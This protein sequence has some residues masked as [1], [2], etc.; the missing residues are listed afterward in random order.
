MDINT[1]F[2]VLAVIWV[3]SPIPL[4]VLL[5]SEK[6]KTKDLR[7]NERYLKSEL[8]ILR[9]KLSD[10]H[11]SGRMFRDESWDK[12]YEHEA[13]PAETARAE[14][15][16]VPSSVPA[17][18]KRREQA[19]QEQAKPVQTSQVAG[20]VRPVQPARPVYSAPQRKA[21]PPVYTYGAVSGQQSRPVSD[22]RPAEYRNSHSEPQTEKK[23]ASPINIILALGTLF[24]SLA[25]FVFAGSAWGMLS[26]LGRGAVLISFSVLFF[27]IHIIAE[28][29]L[30][31]PSAGKV[32]YILGSV[33]LPA[34]VFSAAVLKVFGDG[35]SFSDNNGGLVIS[36][37]ALCA[38]ICSLTG[39][40]HYDSRRAARAGYIFITLSGAAIGVFLDGAF[41]AAEMAVVA[42]VI[43]MFEGPIKRSEHINK[44]LKDEYSFFVS[45][46]IYVSAL[47]SLFLS[48]GSHIFAVPVLIF[49]AAFLISALRRSQKS[50]D[51]LAFCVYIMIGAYLAVRPDSI[52]SGLLL[53]SLV[54]IVYSVLS[55]MDMVP[56]SLRSAVSAVR[57]IASGAVI[58]VG[59]IIMIANGGFSLPV[60]ISAL[61]VTVQFLITAYRGDKASLYAV[62]PAVILTA[63]EA[64]KLFGVYAPA[65]AVALSLVWLIVMRFAKRYHTFSAD[66]IISVFSAAE[67][68]AASRREYAVADVSAVLWVMLMACAFICALRPK[69]GMG[70]FGRISA[71][72][73]VLMMVFPAYLYTH[74][75]E[76]TL[77]AV[78]VCQ[79]LFSVLAVIV[80]VEKRGF[81]KPFECGF[82]VVGAVS[83]ILAA[84]NGLDDSGLVVPLCIAGYFIV[85]SIVI[86]QS[87]EVD[88]IFGFGSDMVFCLYFGLMLFVSAP[89]VCT[90]ALFVCLIVTAALSDGKVRAWALPAALLLLIVPV[91]K[92]ITDADM[93]ATITASVYGIVT[94][95]AV[96][97]GKGI[98]KNL[99]ILFPALLIPVIT[100]ADTRCITA[101]GAVGAAAFLCTAAMQFRK[102]HNKLRILLSAVTC[103][104]FY[105]A[106]FCNIGINDDLSRLIGVALWIFTVVSLAL[107][108]DNISKWLFPVSLMSL[109]L[110]MTAFIGNNN[111]EL[112]RDVSGAASAAVFIIG[113]FLTGGRR[114][115]FKA[116]GALLLSLPAFIYT[117]YGQE[118][119]FTLAAVTAAVLILY[120]TVGKESRSMRRFAAL[121]ISLSIL[122]VL[123]GLCADIH[124]YNVPAR[125][126]FGLIWLCIPVA[127]TREYRRN[128]GSYEEIAV[129]V[130]LP[131][132]YIVAMM[133]FDIPDLSMDK[134][135]LSFAAMIAVMCIYRLLCLSGRLISQKM[136][137]LIMPISL[138]LL[139]VIDETTLPYVLCTAAVLAVSFA[140]AYLSDK[141]GHRRYIY[142]TFA[143]LML[144]AYKCAKC[145]GGEHTRE[146][147]AVCLTAAAVLVMLPSLLTNR[148]FGRASKAFTFGI[149]PVVSAYLMISAVISHSLIILI[150]SYVLAALSAS[151]AY[152]MENTLLM[153]V[154]LPFVHIGTYMFTL[155]GNTLFTLIPAAVTMITGR[156]MFRNTLAKSRRFSD[157]FAITSVFGIAP[158]LAA[159]DRF[160]RWWAM[161]ALAVWFVSLYRKGDKPVVRNTFL[162]LA[163]CLTIPLWWF[164]PFF[165]VPEIVRTEVSL[166]PTVIALALIY[167]I[168]KAH[169]EAVDKVAFIAAVIELL[170]LFLDAAK[171][172]YA[173][174][175]VFLGGVILCILGLSFVYR[176]KRWFAL[177]VCAAV[178]EALLMTVKL[179]NSRIWWVYLLI[180]GVILI[181]V[182]IGNEMKKKRM[183]RG[184]KTR[185]EKVMEEWTW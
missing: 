125:V 153:Y 111:A 56:D 46:N 48:D 51:M 64:G 131:V 173:F 35:F 144:L 19:V 60:M 161:L 170:I 118:C 3:L 108:R 146:L 18:D 2:A 26:S 167:L 10:I 132:S 145:M 163:A 156:L 169:R 164:E 96:F 32:F 113:M 168:H 74:D 115:Q 68:A 99:I 137:H 85:R 117:V 177:A 119:S 120:S 157:A 106:A 171:T 31:L 33:F 37:M 41:A 123:S 66:V 40:V 88:F 70:L 1:V 109:Y 58:A 50:S 6:R 12:K 135:A 79:A 78:A 8:N 147:V 43:M 158:L 166:V 54:M 159:D 179:W 116:A 175:A 104:A 151:A 121:C 183:E 122:F 92:Y 107:G 181:A 80:P 129:L 90:A 182:G 160:T 15:P 23:P 154:L 65:A 67:L 7:E 101:L 140:D 97:F 174:D 98:R 126:V 27:V 83:L 105:V 29:K 49:S 73:S 184:E 59:L 185:L 47:V 75:A 127:F 148:T 149:M 36:V 57:I 84:I 72:V 180:A 91:R 162:T 5:M 53:F 128:G 89:P 136:A 133:I 139:F 112:F 94:A 16:A 13:P 141:S 95:A 9:A 176:Q 52:D 39:A 38:G 124:I 155:D 24:V 138:V 76:M 165:E 103:A 14:T 152:G 102:E 30:E 28:K 93:S 150:C 44:N 69:E 42:F 100:A 130:S 86:R 61:C 81:A 134:G 21:S 20:P 55:F 172:G 4:F 17:A 62:A 143:A 87:K 110:P 63:C 34:A 25:G 22:V 11:L 142:P 178:A 82:A 71:A 114:M 45:E 77:T